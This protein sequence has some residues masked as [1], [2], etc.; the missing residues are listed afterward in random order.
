MSCTCSAGS[1][2]PSRCSRWRHRPERRNTRSRWRG[3]IVYTSQHF[4]P[5]KMCNNRAQSYCTR[6]LWLPILCDM[7]C[8]L[9]CWFC[10]LNNIIGVFKFFVP[11]IWP[12]CLCWPCCIMKLL[13]FYNSN[14][15]YLQFSEPSLKMRRRREKIL[16]GKRS[17]WRERREKW[18]WGFPRLRIRPRKQRKVHDSFTCPIIENGSIS[19]DRYCLLVHCKSAAAPC[20]WL[21]HI[22]QTCRCSWT[23]PSGWKRRGEK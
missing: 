15:R 11:L 6:S 21:L 9:L 17:R 13:H 4:R 23:G 10:I 18:C 1:L 16:R 20:W 12:Q 14:S 2:T 22:A 8:V 7:G 3:L 19:N 5:A